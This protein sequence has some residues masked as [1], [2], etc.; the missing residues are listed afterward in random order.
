V[1]YA[2]TT[3]PNRVTSNK[4]LK[5]SITELYLVKLLTHDVCSIG[6]WVLT[7]VG[8]GV[9]WQGDGHLL[10]GHAVAHLR[11]VT[12]RKAAAAAAAAAAEQRE[13]E[14]YR[15]HQ[16]TRW[17]ARPD[18]Q[19][20]LSSRLCFA[21]ALFILLHTKQCSCYLVSFRH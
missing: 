1:V 16:L 17:H 11:R 14:Q 15:I 18:Q 5:G 4:K 21:E 20:A 13:E 2:C 3:T 8:E 6:V 9:T 10:H 19:L 7:M 12:D